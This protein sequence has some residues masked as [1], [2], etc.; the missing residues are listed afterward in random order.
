MNTSNND[1]PTGAPLDSHHPIVFRRGFAT[2]CSWIQWIVIFGGLIAQFAAAAL[3]LFADGYP[4][5]LIALC[6]GGASLAGIVWAQF[7]RH[8][9]KKSWWGDHYG[10]WA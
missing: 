1:N 4:T 9:F 2:V 10:D 7:W 3:Y 8:L 6:G 5:S